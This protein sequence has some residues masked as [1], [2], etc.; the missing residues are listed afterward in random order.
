MSAAYDNVEYDEVQK[1][2]VHDMICAA[3]SESHWRP[4]WIITQ[5]DADP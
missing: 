3:V 5:A 4:V 2:N 1:W